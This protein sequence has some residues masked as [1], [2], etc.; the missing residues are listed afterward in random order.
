MAGACSTHGSRRDSYK[1][2]RRRTG[3]QRPFERTRRRR[4]EN[5]KMYVQEMRWANGMNW[6]ASG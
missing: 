5:I 2:L 1:V 4:E 6:S 3:G